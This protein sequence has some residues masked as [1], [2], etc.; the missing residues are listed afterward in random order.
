MCDHRISHKRLVLIIGLL[1]C[2]GTMAVRANVSVVSLF[3]DHM[4][5]QRGKPVQVYGT[6]AVGEVVVV[7]F[8]GQSVT[9][10]TDAVGNWSVT[11]AAMAAALKLAAEPAMQ[12]KTIVVILPDSGERYLSS[13]LFDGLFSE[14]ELQQ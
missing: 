12:G 9:N 4:V 2:F 3:S 1:A 14:Q 6:A 10:T 7:S 8:N 5:I 13:M 11:L